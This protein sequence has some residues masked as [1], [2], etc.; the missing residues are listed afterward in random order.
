MWETMFCPTTGEIVL[1]VHRS[2]LS[3]RMLSENN[4]F[5]PTDGKALHL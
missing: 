2:E 1:I 3:L 4:T 5:Y